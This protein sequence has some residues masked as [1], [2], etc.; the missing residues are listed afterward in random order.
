MARSRE[1]KAGVSDLPPARLLV[2][3]V[4]EASIFR[5]QRIERRLLFS[6]ETCGPYRRAL[7]KQYI[8]SLTIRATV[9]DFAVVGMHRRHMYITESEFQAQHFENELHNLATCETFG[10]RYLTEYH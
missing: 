2:P 5:L 7:H 6:M 3:L 8:Y 1:E 4:V 10:S 9:A